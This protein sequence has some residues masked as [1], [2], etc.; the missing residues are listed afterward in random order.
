VAA[1]TALTAA[2]VL[3]FL[4]LTSGSE[5]SRVDLGRTVAEHGSISA[6][7][8]RDRQAALSAAMTRTVAE[9]GSINA[10]EHRDELAA[11][12]VTMTRTVAERGSINAIEH[13][14]E[15]AARDAEGS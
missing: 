15:L 9:H 10:I 1:L 11:R 8:H 7:D 5:P 3:L 4:V 13:R 12:G 2:G 14:D 6:I